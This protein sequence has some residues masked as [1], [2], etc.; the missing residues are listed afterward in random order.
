MGNSQSF[1]DRINDQEMY[2]KE[3]LNDV[4]QQLSSYNYT[5]SQ[6]KGKLRQ[7]YN[8]NYGSNDYITNHR[9]ENVKL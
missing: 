5:D 9:W 7:E 4:K 1:D 2:V 3:K 6:I 8:K